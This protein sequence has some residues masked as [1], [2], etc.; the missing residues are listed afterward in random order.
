MWMKGL[1]IQG[2]ESEV[3]PNGDKEKKRNLYQV[4]DIYK[5]SQ[6]HYQ[7]NHVILV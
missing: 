1:K 3:R 2:L 7:D 5:P 4:Q 6:T